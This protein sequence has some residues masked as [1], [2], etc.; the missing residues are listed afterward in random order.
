MAYDTRHACRPCF[1]TLSTL[2]VPQAF[3]EATH[4]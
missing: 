1:P 3:A 2:R 4:L